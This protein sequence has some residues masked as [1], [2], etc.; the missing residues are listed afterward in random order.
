M[1]IT[2]DPEPSVWYVLAI[3][4]TFFAMGIGSLVFAGYSLSILL[5]ELFGHSQLV[6]FDKGSF[7][8]FGVGSTLIT[9]VIWGFLSK[10]YNKKLPEKLSKLFYG[11]FIASLLLTFALPQIAHMTVNNYLEGQNY[12]ICEDKSHRWLHA[13]TIVYGKNSACNAQ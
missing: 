2:T 8:M 13:V 7:Y 3:G 6:N 12:Q 4:V 9:I 11:V 1:E 5:T 10:M